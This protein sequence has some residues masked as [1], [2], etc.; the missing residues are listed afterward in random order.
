MRR[1]PAFTMIEL[2]VVMAIISILIAL[3]LPAIQSIREM[4]RRTQCANNLMQLGVALGN[5]ASTHRV[6]PPGVVDF[7]RPVV[8][9]PQGYHH[10]W[11]VQVLPFLE[12][13]NVYQRF[14]FRSGVYAGANETAARGTRI[15][16]FLCPSSSSVGPMSY[17]GCHHD[18]EAPIDVDN[19]GVLYLN[20]HVAFDEISDGL[21]NTI[22]LGE[23]RN[24]PSLGWASG[25]RA[26]LRN[27]GTRINARDPTT[28]GPGGG[29]FPGPY[30]LSQAD[31]L[32]T[33]QTMV[34]DGVLPIGFVG[35]FSSFHPSASNFLFCDG[36]VHLLNVSINEHVFRLLGNRADGEIID[37]DDY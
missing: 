3:L 8:N 36:S 22:L 18:V 28:V 13:R 6:L 25:T 31:D 23:V 5:Y 37:A 2:L 15:H 12:Q 10:S 11:V 33:V 21:A 24:G 35:G 29:A 9:A 20:S 19:H 17:V 30:P 34:D 1:R 26:S 7:T 27:T 14:D 16:T 4:A 32:A